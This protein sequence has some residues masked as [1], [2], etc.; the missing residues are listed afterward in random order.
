MELFL[1]ARDDQ[2]DQIVLDIDAT[3]DIVHGE[4]EGRFYHGYYDNYCFLPLYIFCG[5]FLLASKLRSADQDAAAGSL[6]ELQRV[7][8]QIRERWPSVRIV[9]R[10]DSGFCRDW[11]LDWCECWPR[12]AAL[13]RDAG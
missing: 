5:G 12:I 9:I 3:S 1:D 4:Q 13:V 6:E 11:L 7:V 10:G 8:A 2:P